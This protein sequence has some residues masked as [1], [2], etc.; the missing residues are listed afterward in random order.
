MLWTADGRCVCCSWWKRL[1]AK[2][3]SGLRILLRFQHL[4]VCRLLH[5][6]GNPSVIS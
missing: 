6:D 3:H 2:G 1:E 4:T 5:H